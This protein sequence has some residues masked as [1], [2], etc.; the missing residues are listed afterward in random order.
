[1]KQKTTNDYANLLREDNILAFNSLFKIYYKKL[2]LHANDFLFDF[3][4]SRDVVQSVFM[5]LW[6]NRKELPEFDNFDSYIY[7]IVRNRA[8]DI[9]KKQTSKNKYES[10]ILNLMNDY[11]DSDR[12]RE[13]EELSLLIK[14][15]IEEFPEILKKIYHLKNQDKKQKEIASILSVSEKTIERKFS[16]IKKSIKE[17]IKNYYSVEGF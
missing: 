15:K 6:E 2:C 7:T 5:K 8:K 17:I 14:S 16:E 9:L 4:Q 1:V 10:H 13:V 12:E 11:F 3:E